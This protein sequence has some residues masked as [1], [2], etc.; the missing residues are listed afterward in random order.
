MP[1]Q[2]QLQVWFHWLQNTPFATNIRQADLLFPLIEGTHIL[3]LSFSVGLIV[4][5]DLRLLSLAFRG[6]AVSK[7]M[8]QVM[9]WALPGFA[10]MFVSGIV[11]FITQAEK[12]YSNTFF[13]FKILF[14]ILAGLNALFYQLKFYPHMK[15]WDTAPSVPGGARLTAGLSLFLWVAIIALGRTMA[16]EL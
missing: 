14:L 15:E 10:V 5:L 9:P 16:Y 4:M 3:A 11:L 2:A 7:V 13:R 1:F 6:E 8:H 12:A